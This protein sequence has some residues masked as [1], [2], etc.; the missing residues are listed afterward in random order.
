PG[1]RL[2]ANP[3]GDPRC[4][5]PLARGEPR[6]L[7]DGVLPP[8]GALDLDPA[9]RRARPCVAGFRRDRHRLRGEQPPGK[10]RRSAAAVPPLPFSAA[11]VVVAAAVLGL[12]VPTP[13]GLGSYQ[14]AVLIA[15]TDV[16]SVDR[17]TA[18]SVAVVAWVTSFVPI[19][20]IGLALLLLPSGR[21]AA[22]E[23]ENGKRETGNE[24]S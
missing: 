3:A 2:R 20:L 11:Y 9:A 10:G 14:V 19:T 7:P 4:F 24:S 21:G 8:R 22:R 12:A 18:T 5:A 16:F 6:R 15:L 23:T 17:A 13:G 1:S